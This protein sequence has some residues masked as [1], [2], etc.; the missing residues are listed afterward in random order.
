MQAF[1]GFFD[2][3]FMSLGDGHSCK[4]PTGPLDNPTHWKQAIF[5]LREGPHSVTAG[6]IVQ[7]SLECLKRSESDREL[8]VCIKYEILNDQ[9][10]SLGCFEQSWVLA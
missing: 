10:E 4:L 1:C 6:S 2:V 3:M 8:S 7:G 5:L 9:M